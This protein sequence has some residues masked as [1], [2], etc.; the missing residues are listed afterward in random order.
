MHVA[1]RLGDESL[2]AALLA[3]SADANAQS[4]APGKRTSLLLGGFRKAHGNICAFGTE[5][6]GSVGSIVHWCRSKPVVERKGS[7]LTFS[8]NHS[9][10]YGLVTCMS[11]NPIQNKL[12]VRVIMISRAHIG[13]HTYICMYIYIHTRAVTREHAHMLVRTRAHKHALGLCDT[14]ARSVTSGPV[15]LACRM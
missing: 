9:G 10:V 13:T 4:K 2:V 6:R 12:G 11:P 14:F 15:P 5:D 7:W 8:R 3:G 1:V